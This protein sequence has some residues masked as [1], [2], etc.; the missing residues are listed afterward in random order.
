MLVGKGR[1]RRKE[2]E[3]VTMGRERQGSGKWTKTSERR[4]NGREKG[5]EG[6]RKEVGR[7]GKK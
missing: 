6:G 3:G 2:K 1:R 7:E 5:R 4:E